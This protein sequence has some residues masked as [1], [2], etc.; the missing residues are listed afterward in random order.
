[1]HRTTVVFDL[2]ALFEV[3]PLAGG[4]APDDVPARRSWISNRW[5]DSQP[6]AHTS[7]PRDLT[8]DQAQLDQLIMDEMVR[9][10]EGGAQ[11]VIVADTFG[12]HLEAVEE[13]CKEQ[14]ISFYRNHVDAAQGGLQFPYT[15]R[16]CPC[17]TCGVCKQ[18]IIREA[19]SEG[20][21]TVLVSA[22][23]SDKKSVLLADQAV[24][25]GPLAAWASRFDVPHV[26]VANRNQMVL[27]V[28]AL[29]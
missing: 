11:L 6:T 1:M 2:P 20:R 28:E 21:R 18:W 25:S 22:A 7:G 29:L 27:G 23:L 26:M 16:C 9:W 5:D 15:E 14:S 8:A 4:W 12:D 17:L 10:G 24:L 13:F 3:V 19:R